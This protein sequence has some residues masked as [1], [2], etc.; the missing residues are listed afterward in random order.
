M[1]DTK[2]FIGGEWV[3]PATDERIEVISPHTEEPV[4]Q[5]AAASP[6]D[7]DRA[8]AAAR[9]AFDD[10]PWPRL[11]PAER[12]EVVRRLASVY[13]ERRVEMAD[14][15]TTEL[16]APTSFANRAQVALPW[17]IMNVLAGI[18]ETYPWQEPRPGA[19]GS[20][21]IIRKEPVGV[22]AAI[23]P[24]NMPQFLITTKLVPALLAGCTVVLKPS[25]ESPLDAL[26]LAQLLEEVGLPPGVVSILPGGRETGA[27]LVAN[28]GV[29][30]VSFTGSTAAGRQVARECAA[31]LTRV[32]LE[33]GGK[34]AA[35]ALADADPAAVA[36]AV[37]ISGMGMAGQICNALTRVIA[38]AGRADEFADA[39]ASELSGLQIGDPTDPETQ[40]GPLVAQRQQRR[41]RD[42]IDAGVAEGARMVVGG[43]ELP[44]EVDRGWYVRPTVFTD[45]DNS[46]RVAREEIFGPVLTVIPYRDE[47]DALRIAN[48]SDYGLAGSVFTNDVDHG[49]E[50]AARVRAGTIGVNGGY[51]MDPAAPFGGVK[52]SGYGRELGREGLEGYL[53]IKS[54]S[55]TPLG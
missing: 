23:I 13:G 17:T 22:V 27:H 28:A 39:L 25:P 20:D 41:V 55:V 50:V 46:M 7:A 21:V 49:L 43:T 31:N 35:I 9:A 18:A 36:T 16:G 42:Y 45:A 51:A 2:L 24:W 8:V 40:V 52:A 10:G 54:I 48:D 11:D 37:R 6:A 1:Q 12:I 29:D 32:S 26:L 4:A 47:A 44:D 38:P 5:V 33:L 30:K 14:V 34:S 15:I 53:D 3:E 19:F